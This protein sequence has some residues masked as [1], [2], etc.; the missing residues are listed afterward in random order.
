[1]YMY[2]ATKIFITIINIEMTMLYVQRAMSMSLCKNIA[3]K[4]NFPRRLMD[5]MDLYPIM[6]PYMA[7]PHT[8]MVVVG[9][10]LAALVIQLYQGSKWRTTQSMESRYNTFMGTGDKEQ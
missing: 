3:F 2:S 9:Y 4:M 6:L 7:L 8:P 1:M 10:S 5:V